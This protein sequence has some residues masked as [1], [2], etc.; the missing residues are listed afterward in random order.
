[1][2][3]ATGPPVTVVSHNPNCEA[4]GLSASG[5]AGVLATVVLVARFSTFGG[6][7]VSFNAL[8]VGLTDTHSGI[9]LPPSGLTGIGNTT[10]LA[11][12]GDVNEPEAGAL[13]ALGVACVHRSE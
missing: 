2:P 10:A 13:G 5:L 7:G 1:M 6:E 8:P 3:F 11:F 9:G 12:V 4:L